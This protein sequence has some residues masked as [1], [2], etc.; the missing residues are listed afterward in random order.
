MAPMST[1]NST[2]NNHTNGLNVPRSQVNI[3]INSL[4]YTG[5]E[6]D[7]KFPFLEPSRR[8]LANDSCKLLRNVIQNVQEC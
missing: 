8:K 5:D 1:R 6:A 7:L 2:M 4:N 3:N